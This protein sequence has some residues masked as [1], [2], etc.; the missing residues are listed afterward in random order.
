LNYNQAVREYENFADVSLGDEAAGP[1]GQN[2]Q[3]PKNFQGYF[4]PKTSRVQQHEM[5][6]PEFEHDQ[7]PLYHHGIN[8]PKNSFVPNHKNHLI[9]V[10][11]STDQTLDSRQPK[12]A[13]MHNNFMRLNPQRQLEQNKSMDCDESNEVQSSDPQR[14]NQSMSSINADE[15]DERPS[16]HFVNSIQ[17][18]GIN[19]G[20][21]PKDGKPLI[22]F[23]PQPEGEAAITHEVKP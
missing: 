22:P 14:Q 10:P 5:L 17:H 20:F 18:H 16:H 7:G 12:P 2:I 19:A 3:K 11:Q 23:M 9:L 6:K 15:P 21:V 4:A 8:P 13:T 1:N